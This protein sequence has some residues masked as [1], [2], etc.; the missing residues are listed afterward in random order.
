M[1]PEGARAARDVPSNTADLVLGGAALAALAVWLVFDP[2]GPATSEW[3]SNAAQTL[4]PAM[5]AW[6]AWRRSAAAGGAGRAWR[7]LALGCLAWSVGH[8]AYA[9]PDLAGRT[10]PSFPSVAD[11]GFLALIPLALAGFLSH[12][13]A[14]RTRAGLLRL[15]ADGL[16]AGGSARFILWTLLLASV[17]A[18]ADPDPFENVAGLAYAVGDFVILTIG[19][20]I[21]LRVTGRRRVALLIAAMGFAGLAV[22]DGLFTYA[23]LHG[24]YE[25]GSA[26]DV[27]WIAGF[28]A[29][30]YA[31]RFDGRTWGDVAE[32]STREGTFGQTLLPYALVGPALVVGIVDGAVTG[33]WD[34]TQFWNG[35]VVAILVLARQVADRIQNVRLV[36]SLRLTVSELRERDAQLEEAQRLASV[37]SWRW[38]TGRPGVPDTVEWTDEVYRLFGVDRRTFT[39][40]LAAYLDQVHSDDRE[41]VGGIIQQAIERRGPFEFEHRGGFENRLLQC[42]G[43]ATVDADGNFTGLVGTI[44][45]ITTV[46]RLAQELERRLAELERSNA[47]L[48]HFASVASHDLAAPVQLLIGHLRLLRERTR[49]GLDPTSIGLIEGAVRGAQRL[50]ELI[51]DI[52]DYSLA[53]SG[54]E[55]LRASVDLARVAREA[56][57]MV[58]AEGWAARIEIDDDMPVVEAHPGQVRRLFQNLLSNAL[59]FVPADRQPHIRVWAER[60]E[61]GTWCFSVADNGVG[62]APADRERIFHMF[63]RGEGLDVGGTGIGLAICSRIVA[64]H[65]GHLWVEAAPGGG[66]VFRFTLAEPSETAA[67]LA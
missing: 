65:A 10:Q 25:T 48:S 8:L 17:H 57:R 67:S 34:A 20:L 51:Q 3:V 61:E 39:P 23:S 60:T 52:L 56:S 9:V 21:A 6:A 11:L 63:E 38:T 64:R 7:L 47:D 41:R 19:V 12:P 18:G 1:K 14:P 27:T 26:A 4:A 33:D 40:T 54:E 24:G 46:R 28:M 16:I 15:V 29:I 42:R 30:A 66:S 55:D 45:D 22:G 2:A 50:E 35:S 37:G 44:Q 43:H 49:E 62:V 5:A 59:K 58:G 31:A 36:D 32:E 13:A 53:T